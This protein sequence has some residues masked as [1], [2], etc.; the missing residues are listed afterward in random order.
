MQI[1]AGHCSFY[2]FGCLSFL[3]FLERNQLSQVGGCGVAP[4]R[5]CPHPV[6]PE[7]WALPPD[8]NGLC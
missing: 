5:V 3:I 6:R 2:F 4:N 8:E 7:N 1:N